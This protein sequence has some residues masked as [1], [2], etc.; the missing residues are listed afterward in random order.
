VK[1]PPLTDLPM[2][3]A[4][5]S[6]FRHWFDRSW[7]FQDQFELQPFRVPMLTPYV[8]GAVLA[9]GLPIAWAVKLSTCIMLGLLPI[10]LAVYCKGLKKSPLLGVAAAGLAWGPM[11]HWGFISF[12]GAL[13]LMML[14]V[15]VTLLLVERPTRTRVV[16]LGVVSALILVTHVSRFPVYV[17][18]VSIATIAMLPV[19]R[20]ARPVIVALVPSVMLFAAWWLARPPSLS[21]P[22]DLGWH[23]ERRHKIVDHVFHSFQGTG[24][25]A[26]LQQMA[27]IV[28]AVGVY[29][30]ATKVAVARRAKRPLRISRRAVL[31]FGGTFVIAAMSALLYFILPMKIG[32]WS[33]VYPR[34]AS[35]A[36]LFALPL[37]PSLPQS[38]WLRAPAL[39]ALLL[40]I[41]L[42]MRFITNKY[43]AFERATRDFQNIVA[44]LPR[45]PKLAYLMFDLSGSDAIA[46]PF[47]HLPA[48]VQAERGGWLSFHFA[49]WNAT[50]IR[51]RTS[52]P[53]DVAPDTP[54]HFEWE[55][56]R[57]DIA[58]RGK[59]FDWF[60]V[61]TKNSPEER[62]EVDPSLHLVDRRG[63]WWLYKRD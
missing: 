17:A 30:F 52:D 47:V 13:G 2:H 12:V 27:A 33:W 11:T 8:L 9:L 5:T 45:A 42:P 62:F 41:G 56:D 59:Y 38:P 20:R 51:F 54:D 46:K 22:M 24:E 28:L 60:L 55:P 57:F 61:R 15:G 14:G 58:T 36:V 31:A 21:A 19:T 40:G 50:P 4:I 3:A 35:A 16:T 37:L 1:Y 43:A 48:W 32:Q 18:A 23:F 26:I 49:T 29:S 6:T 44:E 10:G 34:E 39:A 7:H 63:S 53:K 25:V